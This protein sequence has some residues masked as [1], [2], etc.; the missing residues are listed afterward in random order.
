MKKSLK[1]FIIILIPLISAIIVGIYFGYFKYFEELQNGSDNVDAS[2]WAVIGG[3]F[4]SFFGLV[5]GVI[6]SL[7]IW[8]IVTSREEERNK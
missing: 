1:T 3:F 8:M 6:L 2:R 4:Y 5:P 7:F